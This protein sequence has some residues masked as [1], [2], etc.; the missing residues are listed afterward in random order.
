VS[1][2]PGSR[3]LVP[4]LTA[5]QELRT[6]IPVFTDTDRQA[7]VQEALRWPRRIR[8]PGASALDSDLMNP[9]G[10]ALGDDDLLAIE[11]VMHPHDGVLRDMGVVA[12][13]LAEL[14]VEEYFENECFAV[15]ALVQPEAPAYDPHDGSLWSMTMAIEEGGWFT[16]VEFRS[17]D[18][19]DLQAHLEWIEYLKLEKVEAVRQYIAGL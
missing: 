6:I 10:K 14:A 12:A 7:F 17:A 16:R 11:A 1:G 9:S 18:Y 5:K 13:D 2:R 3:E 8:L 19:P 15:A 4:W